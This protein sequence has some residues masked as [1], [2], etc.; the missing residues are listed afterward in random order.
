MKNETVVKQLFE[1]HTSRH[2]MMSQNKTQHH[3][4]SYIDVYKIKGTFTPALFSPV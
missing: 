1:A 3:L 4:Y 2:I